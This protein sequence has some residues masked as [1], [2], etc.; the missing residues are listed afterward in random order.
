MHQFKTNREQQWAKLEARDL[1]DGRDKQ[2]MAKEKKY[3]F[4][5]PD[6]SWRSQ[7]QDYL[8]CLVYL[9]TRDFDGW[10]RYFDE[11]VSVPLSRADVSNLMSG[12]LGD[13]SGYF[14]APEDDAYY[15]QAVF[16]EKWMPDT[17]IKLSFATVDPL[18]TLDANKVLLKSG[19]NLA[20]W[21]KADKNEDSG[22]GYI[23]FIPEFFEEVPKHIDSRVYDSKIYKKE[24]VPP[25]SAVRIRGLKSAV[26][27]IILWAHKPLVGDA[28]YDERINVAKQFFA[29]F[30]AAKDRYPEYDSCVA[31]VLEEGDD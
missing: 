14:Q 23:R 15:V 4:E 31:R 11:F 5:G 3:F 24:T 21:L 28:Y 16:G 2:T 20:S 30:E 22:G 26:R 18:E 19:L 27:R 1:L 6:G 9:P 17:K 12:I 13:G 25:N 10:Q 29:M 7:S 8:T